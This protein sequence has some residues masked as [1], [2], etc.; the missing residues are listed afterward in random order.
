MPIVQ[1]LKTILQV[2]PWGIR[3]SLNWI[4]RAYNN[5]RIIITENGVSLER[6]LRDKGRTNYIRDYLKYV[7][8]AITKD[9]CNVYGYTYWSLMDNFEWLRGFS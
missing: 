7:H 8:A 6:G 4:K 2:V 3:L 9:N 5:P 1:Y